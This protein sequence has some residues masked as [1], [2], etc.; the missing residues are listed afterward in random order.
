M[1]LLIL[2]MRRKPF[3][4][5][6]LILLLSVGAALG[7]VGVSAYFAANRQTETAA[8]F[9]TTV[10]IPAGSAGT[11]LRCRRNPV[12]FAGFGAALRRRAAAGDH[13]G[14]RQRQAP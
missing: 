2:W 9:Y 3:V 4:S 5:L 12:R 1:N 14:Q 13:T 11:V 6:L 10:A 7:S 8:D